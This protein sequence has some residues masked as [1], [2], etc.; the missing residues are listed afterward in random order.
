MYQKL[1]AKSHRKNPEGVLIALPS[2]VKKVPAEY[3]RVDEQLGGAIARVIGQSDFDA[4]PGMLITSQPARGAR[5]LYIVGLGSKS[6]D[7]SRALRVGAAKSVAAAFN[8]KLATVNVHLHEAIRDVAEAMGLG[9]FQAVAFKGTATPKKPGPAKLTLG[10]TAG[11]IDDAKHGLAVADAANFARQLAAT[12]PNICNPRYL[13]NQSRQ[14]ARKLGLKCTII[15]AKRAAAMNMGGITSVGSAGSTPPALIVLEYSP[16]GARNHGKPVALVGK[17]VTF[18]TGGYS[19][20]PTDSMKS[21][22][23]DKCGGMA[24]LGALHAAASLKLPVHVI[25]FIPTVENMISDKAYRVDDILTMHN[26]VTV[27]ITNTDAEGRLILADAL[28]YACKQHKP[29]A[30]V[31][32]ATLTG[33]VVT[34]LGSYCA[35]MFCNDTKLRTRLNNAGNSCGE[36]LWHLPLWP[37]HKKQMKS[38]HADIVNSAGREAHPI[39]GAAFLWH[40][41]DE[42]MPW[43]HLDIAGVADVAADRDWSGLYPKGP[44]GFGV[45]LLT[46]MLEEWR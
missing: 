16:R 30:I 37:E 26:G 44:T 27:E 13:V 19:L 45:R 23:Y 28:S 8:A 9:N 12:P 21:M 42:K 29:A 6:D 4:A 36:R 41:V 18:D 17:A 25:G 46:R 34:A 31:D 20:K 39:Q 22:K 38:T 33:G 14:M 40:F 35:G 11:Q 3:R 15:D 7:A 5:R 24:V 32:L 43:A 1:D 10:L 2:N